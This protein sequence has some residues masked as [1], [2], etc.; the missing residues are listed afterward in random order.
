MCAPDLCSR[1]TP[2]VSIQSSGLSNVFFTFLQFYKMTQEDHFN[3]VT[4][5]AGKQKCW[6]LLH[7]RQSE[8]PDS[9]PADQ[10]GVW[11]IFDPDA[12]DVETRSIYL[13]WCAIGN[14]GGKKSVVWFLDKTFQ[15]ER[16]GHTSERRCY[17]QGSF[18]IFWK[19]LRC[20]WFHSCWLGADFFKLHT[21]GFLPMAKPT[22]RKLEEIGPCRT[23]HS[24]SPSRFWTFLPT[25]RVVWE[26]HSSIQNCT[27]VSP[28]LLPEVIAVFQWLP[29]ISINSI[30]LHSS[31]LGV[32]SCTRYIDIYRFKNNSRNSTPGCFSFQTLIKLNGPGTVSVGLQ[33]NWDF[34]WKDNSL[35]ESFK[36][37]LNS[38]EKY[39]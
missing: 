22:T 8:S 31:A 26:N 24:H 11:Y 29:T 37:G 17:F 5:S 6:S 18:K 19:Q 35:Q 4:A 27:L 7:F 20:S 3:D 33:V 21:K 12:N 13:T 25:E 34:F 10:H 9:R 36:R 30:L 28:Q 2:W 39:M 23:P 38:W 16:L 1:L 14:D 32:C 15:G